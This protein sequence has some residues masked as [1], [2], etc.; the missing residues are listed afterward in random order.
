MSNQMV[1]IKTARM[2]ARLPPDICP[3]QGKFMI[4]S[5]MSSCTTAYGSW[6]YPVHYPS[7]QAWLKV[8]KR[9]QFAAYSLFISM[10]SLF[11]IPSRFL[12]FLTR[13]I[14]C[15]SNR[16]C[17]PCVLSSESLSVTAAM[18]NVIRRLSMSRRL[19]HFKYH[20]NLEAKCGKPSYL[21]S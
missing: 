6:R 11:H 15:S 4:Y 2:P 13:L 21:H 10:E 19:H 12:V 9:M 5:A 16:L 8:S 17:C 7:W 3:P 14:F 18:P 1:M 20:P